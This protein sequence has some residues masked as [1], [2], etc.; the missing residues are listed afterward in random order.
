M[1]GALRRSLRRASLSLAAGAALLLGNARPS[2]AA[3]GEAAGVFKS[4]P[5]NT[6]GDLPSVQ[7]QI[8]GLST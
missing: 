7:H 2:Q 3:F 6:S 8:V 4:K 1:V 5:T